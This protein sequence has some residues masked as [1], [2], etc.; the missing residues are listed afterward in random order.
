MPG[1]NLSLPAQLL[2]VFAHLAQ[3]ARPGVL[4]SRQA[5]LSSLTAP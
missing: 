2:R 3:D 4:F 5:P 1:K